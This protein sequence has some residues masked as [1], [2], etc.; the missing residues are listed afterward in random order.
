MITDRLRYYKHF[1]L[2]NVFILIS[3]WE[4]SNALIPQSMGLISM[5]SVDDNICVVERAEENS[6]E[7][8]FVSFGYIIDVLLFGIR[9]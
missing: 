7:G 4:A 6:S 5:T 3:E 9:K 1:G 2:V 8:T